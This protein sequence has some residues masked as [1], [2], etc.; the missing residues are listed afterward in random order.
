[1]TAW[2]R[3]ASPGV[4]SSLL[5]TGLLVSGDRLS[6]Q[7]REVP[8]DSLRISIPG[9]ARG[10]TFIVAPQA[11]HEPSRADVQPGRRF[12]LSGQK[13]LLDEI[14]A[15]EGTP[16]EV[17]GLVRSSQLSAPQ[18]INIGGGIRVGGGVPRDPMTADPRRDPGYNEVVLDLES[19]RTLPGSCP[20]R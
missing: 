15:R 18:G 4:L 13:K 9:C 2:A 6:A 17:T 5:L 1:M 11:E 19:W 16:V 14:K 3:A 10:R 8:K 7:E 20:A 12:R